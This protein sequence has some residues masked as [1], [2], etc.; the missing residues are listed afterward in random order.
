MNP[1]VDHGNST[2]GCLHAPFSRLP[3]DVLDVWQG[4][5]IAQLTALQELRIGVGHENYTFTLEPAGL[6]TSLQRLT[7]VNGCPPAMGPKLIIDAGPS[8]LAG[9]GLK[10]P[11]SF[12]TE[13]STA[14]APAG[15][16][17]SSATAPPTSAPMAPSAAAPAVAASVP[18]AAGPAPAS[19]AGSA[20]AHLFESEAQAEASSLAP[21]AEWSLTGVSRTQLLSVARLKPAP[22]PPAAPPAS[23]TPAPSAS[24]SAPQLSMDLDGLI[25]VL[26]APWHLAPSCSVTLRTGFLTL[27]GEHPL[28]VGTDREVVSD[29]HRH[30]PT[31]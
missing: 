7:V 29:A 28:E 31:S 1:T 25:L 4:R 15:T 18:A 23:Q 10:R 6:P 14:P 17:N 30:L 12:T 26:P 21:V 24:L 27:R 11:A 22:Y 9:L 16:E 20:A 13:A 8:P 3:I 19:F 5:S 2:N